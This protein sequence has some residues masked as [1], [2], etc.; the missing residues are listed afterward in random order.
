MSDIRIVEDNTRDIMVTGGKLS[1]VVGPQARGQRIGIA[2]R[3]FQGEWFLDQNAGTDFFDKILGKS[4]ALTRRAE[5]H[6]RLV[7]IP[8]IASVQSISLRVDPVT[9]RLSGTVQVLDVTGAVVEATV[10]E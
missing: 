8:G 1:L 2:L 9:R 7:A 10:A 5:I 6:R 4:S 3:H